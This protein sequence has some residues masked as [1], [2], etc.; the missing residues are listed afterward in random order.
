M[1]ILPKHGWAPSSV[2]A[3]RCKACGAEL[4]LTKVI[5]DDMVR[6]LEHHTFICS[7]CHVTQHQLLFMRHGR[8]D[9]TESVPV[10]VPP[11]TAPGSTV[12]AEQVAASGLFSRMFAKMHRH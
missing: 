2:R 7:G 3:M 10:R 12:G 6:A 8:E 4:V 5:P 1:S 9:D 11:R